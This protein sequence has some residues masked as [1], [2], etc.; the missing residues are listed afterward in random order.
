MIATAASG[1][2][3][4]GAVQVKTRSEI[5]INI[6]SQTLII[7]LPTSTSKHGPRGGVVDLRTMLALTGSRLLHT[8]HPQKVNSLAKMTS[9]HNAVKCLPGQ[10]HV[11]ANRLGDSYSKRESMNLM[12]GTTTGFDFPVVA[13]KKA[14]ESLYL[15]NPYFAS[16]A[17]ALKA[18]ANKLS[19][20]GFSY[21]IDNVGLVCLIHFNTRSFP[22]LI[23]I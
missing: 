7:Q 23:N 1:R 22:A 2:F 10:E 3:D 14:M 6:Y 11:R 12:E 17:R 8:R 9:L 16:S 4:D 13:L 19:V 18:R 20:N 5:I 21:L 15:S